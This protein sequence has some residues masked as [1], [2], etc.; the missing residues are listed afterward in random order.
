[1]KSIGVKFHPTSTGV[2]T[3]SLFADGDSPCNDDNSSLTGT[4]VLETNINEYSNS[5]FIVYPNPVSGSSINI[6]LNETLCSD[7]NVISIYDSYGSLLREIKNNMKSLLSVNVSSF[8]S[9][10]FIM[11]YQSSSHVI[12]KTFIVK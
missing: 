5:D 10:M 4:G 6:E 8:G 11:K 3:A 9:G 7:S 2:K 1:T 12:T